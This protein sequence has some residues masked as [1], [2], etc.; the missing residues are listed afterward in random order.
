[1]FVDKNMIYF[2]E[3]QHREKTSK[4][5][6]NGEARGKKPKGILSFMAS[7][8]KR[9]S[10]ILNVIKI[11]FSYTRY[12]SENIEMDFIDLLTC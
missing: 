11:S 8:R 1:M 6:R 10:Q 7:Y 12:T 2:M 3:F 4:N 9:D 5:C